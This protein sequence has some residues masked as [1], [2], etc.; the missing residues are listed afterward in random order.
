[1]AMYI[2]PGRDQPNAPQEV[3]LAR[4]EQCED[5]A[6]ILSEQAQT[7]AFQDNLSPAEVLTRCHQGLLADDSHFNTNEAR[8]IIYRL[9]ELLGWE[10][11]NFD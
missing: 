7:L 8:W 3:V 2:T 6:N 9:A 1:M 10:P 5:M 11:P 4:Y